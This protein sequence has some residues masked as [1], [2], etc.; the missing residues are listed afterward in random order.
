MRS[1][2][3][4]V[5]WAAGVVLLIGTYSLSGC[6]GFF[7]PPTSTGGGTGG[8]AVTPVQSGDWAYIVNSIAMTVSEYAIGS[9]TLTSLTGSPL[10]LAYVPTAAVVARSNKFLYVSGPGAIYLY[11]IASDGSLSA[12]TSGAGVAI[13]TVLSL[14]VS[15]DGQWLFGL[16]ATTQVLDEWAINATTGALTSQAGATYTVTSGVVQPRSVKVA[17]SGAYVFAA[18]GTGGEVVFT[19]NTTTGVVASSQTLGTGS[20]QTSDNAVLVNTASSILYVARSGTNGGVAAFA[21]GNAGVL[22]SLTGS[23]FAAGLGTYDLAFDGTGNYLYAANRS[24]GTISGYTV[25]GTGG[26]TALSGSPYAAGSLVSS[27][28]ADSTGK[29]FVAANFGGTP[30]IA[31]YSVSAATASAGALVSAATVPSGTTAAGSAAV[32]TSY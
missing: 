25:G 7:V 14:A 24:A 16:D 9:G 17:P 32:A 8:G 4:S 19:L 29:Y 2:T 27:L 23:P 6:S 1:G 21:I 31:L 26:L 3:G 11:T 20:T 10:S 22:N 15:P 5:R 18:L 30:D 13:A 12:S 28:R